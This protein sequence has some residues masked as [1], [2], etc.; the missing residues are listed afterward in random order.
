[1]VSRGVGITE[2]LFAALRSIAPLL[3]RLSDSEFNFWG[4]PLFSAWDPSFASMMQS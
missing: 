3:A 4:S 1:M 2:G